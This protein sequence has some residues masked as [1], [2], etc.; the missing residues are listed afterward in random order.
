[1]SPYE[2]RLLI[3]IDVGL[4][5]LT[6]KDTPLLSNTVYD[7]FRRGLIEISEESK[8]N[9]KTTKLGRTVC[10]KFYGVSESNIK[11]CGECGQVIRK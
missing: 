5:P 2:V 10:T 3:E 7:F 9:W 6:I 4:W 11:F 1:M 8:L